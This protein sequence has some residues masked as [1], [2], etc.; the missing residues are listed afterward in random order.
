M[1]DGADKARLIAYSLEQGFDEARVSSADFGKKPGEYLDAFLQAGYHG[2]MDWLVAK[3]KWRRHPQSLW[4][5]AKSALVLGLN[6][7]PASDPRA[8]A[9]HPDRGI[10]SVYAQGKDYHDLIKK[11]LKRIARWI[12]QEFG[13]DVKVFVD[14]APVMEKPLA[15]S[16]GLGW[17]GKHT[18]LLSRNFGSWLFLG[19]ILTTLEIAPDDPTTGD[20]GS[21]TACLD[22]CPTQAFV[23]PYKLD[24]SKCI[25]YLTI[26]TRAHIPRDIRSAMGNR[27]YGCD[28]CLSVCP[29]NKFAKRSREMA[30][31]PRAELTAPRLSDL[32]GL[33]DTAFRE[34][35]SGSPVKRLG[36]NRFI[37]NVLIALGNQKDRSQVTHVTPL[38]EDPSPIIRVAAVWALHQLGSVSD[39]NKLYDACMIR[40]SDPDVIEEWQIAKKER[41][42]EQTG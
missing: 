31:M 25:S 36:R 5:E 7:A 17:Q 11:R 13:A 16:A 2:D 22:V 40:E 42:D 32:A 39:F 4:P 1:I 28:D 15:A 37:R 18:N 9:D 35:F 41:L 12:V 24:A 10:I 38:L 29:W 14:T 6:Y 33:D 34:I 8:L 30:F 27:I 19:C 21:C 20:C 3:Q 23:G 26:E